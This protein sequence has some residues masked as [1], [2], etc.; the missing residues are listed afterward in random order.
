LLSVSAAE[1]VILDTDIER[2]R[3]VGRENVAR[4][5]RLVNYRTNLMREG[6]AESD[7]AEG[8]SDA[9]VDALILHGEPRRVADGIRAHVDA[10][11]DHVCVQVLGGD[12]ID[13]QRRLAQFLLD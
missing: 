5:L 10:G 4:Y 8:G 12:P 3:A 13:G 7:L 9:L 2:A 1:K 6:W 11:A